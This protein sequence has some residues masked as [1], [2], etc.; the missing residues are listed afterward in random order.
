M[1]TMLSLKPSATVL[2][3]GKLPPFH[4]LPSMLVTGVVTGLLKWQERARQRYHLTALDDRTLKDIGLSRAEVYQEAR[5]MFWI[6]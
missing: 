4:K 3:A 6:G 1:M 5:K 2:T